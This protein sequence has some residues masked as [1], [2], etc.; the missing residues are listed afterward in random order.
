MMNFDPKDLQF[1][2]KERIGAPNLLVGRTSEFD[3]YHQWI[4]GIPKEI[5]K[6]RVIIARKK[7]GKTAFLQRLFNE[8]WSAY[9]AVIPFYMEI[10]EQK[11]WYPDFATQYFR[12]FASQY[13]SFLERDPR[14]MK[15]RMSLEAIKAYGKKN[16]IPTF[17]NDVEQMESDHEKGKYDSIWSSVF[18]A[19]HRYADLYGKSILVMIDEFQNLNGFIYRDPGCTDHLDK[20]IPGSYHEVSESKIAPMLVTGSN[21]QWLLE[22]IRQYFQMGRL[23]RIKFSPFL[24]ENEGLEAVYRLA[25]HYEMDISNEVAVTI[26]KICRSDAYFI[27][28]VFRSSYEDKDLKTIEGVKATIYHEVGTPYGEIAQEWYA[29]FEKT[30]SRINE[31]HGK[32]ILLFLNKNAEHAYTPQQIKDAL[33]LDL[34]LDDIQH[35]LETM[36]ELELIRGSIL[37]KQYQGLEDGTFHLA[38]QVRLSAEIDQ[39]DTQLIENIDTRWA[40]MKA[41]N[42]SLQGMLNQSQGELA[43]YQLAF[44]LRNRGCFTL[45]NYFEGLENGALEF[46]INE[47]TRRFFIQSGDHPKQEL[48][49]RVLGTVKIGDRTETRSLLIEVKKKQVRVDLKTVQDFADKVQFY[50]S[51]YPEETPIQAFLALGGFTD[52]AILFCRK[53]RIGT[54]SEIHHH[55]TEWSA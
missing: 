15:E 36:R 9:G 48:D 14:I 25:E 28:S 35:K 12:T 20:T 40:E 32:K 29:Y 51:V 23:Q 6:S 45:R 8:V 47:M 11:L 10:L 5:S 46:T 54:A 31:I 39:F 44:E 30:I 27:S 42:R 13:I 7:S 16:A 26:N 38:L 1:P 55:Q 17:V 3:A 34:S 33:Q 41:K 52:E 43:E 49:L 4:K 2:L 18:T 50:R 53:H 21:V 19:P 22:V 37:S 24:K